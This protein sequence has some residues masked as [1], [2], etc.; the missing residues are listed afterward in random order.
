MSNYDLFTPERKPAKPSRA[1][2]SVSELNRRAK[3][4]L[5]IHLPLIWVEGE[6]S[7]FNKPSSGHWY[8][9][10]KDNKAQVRCAMFKGRNALFRGKPN[11]GDKVKVRARVTLYEGRGDFQLVVEHMEHAG[12]GLLQKKFDLLKAKLQDEGLFDEGNK[13]TLPSQ[14]KKLAVITSA[15]GAAIRDVIAVLQ[16]RF[17]SLPV[18][19]IPTSVQG[20]NAAPEICRALGFADKQGFDVILLCRGGGS[21]EDLWAF[22][23][24]SVARA[25]YQCQ[26]PV[27]SAIGHE[28]DITI[29]D[30]VADL[31]AATPSAG[32]E[33]LSPDG[34]ELHIRFSQ[35]EFRLKT[36][37][38][39]Y[40]NRRYDALASYRRLLRHPGEQLNNWFQRL[41]QLEGKLLGRLEASLLQKKTS[42]NTLHAALLH[43]SPSAALDRAQQ[44]LHSISKALNVAMSHQLTLRKAALSNAANTLQVISPLNTLARGYAIVSDT[45][46]NILRDDST[47]NIGDEVNLRLARSRLKA[48]V[49]EKIINSDD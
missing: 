12:E 32:A 35:M 27:I 34:D 14:S 9:G 15:T 1:V 49:S 20:D 42:L 31:R 3:Q 30:F 8:F 45:K 6:I 13:K 18:S 19:I 4:L 22:N 47:I 36:V 48:Q 44:R 40:L 38:R 28:S 17:P 23:E 33:L 39:Q 11:D 43:S 21:L 37:I 5:E 25:I 46:G 26:T 16:R 2:L 7:N 29:A 41:D 24:E 10:L